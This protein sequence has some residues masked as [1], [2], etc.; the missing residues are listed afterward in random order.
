MG[1]GYCTAVYLQ[2]RNLQSRF[3]DVLQCLRSLDV[4]LCVGIGALLHS[5]CWLGICFTLRSSISSRSFVFLHVDADRRCNHKQY[6]RAILGI[7]LW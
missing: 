6:F 5:L 1:G 4:Q 3:D 7:K 2:A